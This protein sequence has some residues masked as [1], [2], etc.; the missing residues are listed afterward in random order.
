[1][2]KIIKLKK[3]NQDKIKR[4]YELEDCGEELVE[5]AEKLIQ[6]NPSRNSTKKKDEIKDAYLKRAEEYRS[7][8]KQA[9]ELSDDELDSAAGGI[10]RPEDNIKDPFK[11]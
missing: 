7:D 2:S 10:L 5:L 9:Q 8:K 4:Q 1:M 6:C 3:V 11:D